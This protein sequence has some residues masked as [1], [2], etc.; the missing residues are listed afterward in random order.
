MKEYLGK[1]ESV[2]RKKKKKKEKLLKLQ[3]L[4]VDVKMSKVMQS[5]ATFQL[6]ATDPVKKGKRSYAN[7][8]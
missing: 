7:R 5:A 1:E 4:E 2:K 6:Y 3:Q 8:R